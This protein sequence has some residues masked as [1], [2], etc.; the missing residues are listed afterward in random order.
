MGAYKGGVP[1]ISQWG[2]CYDNAHAE[3]FWNCL[4]LKTESL[5]GDM[6]RNALINLPLRCQL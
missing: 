2:N 6:K 5:D 4:K 3:F 1:S